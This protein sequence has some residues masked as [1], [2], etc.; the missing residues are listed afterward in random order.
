MT[1]DRY[2]DIRWFLQDMAKKKRKNTLTD[3]EKEEVSS[4]IKDLTPAIRRFFS[5]SPDM[6]KSAPEGT[7]RAKGDYEAQEI[8]PQLP[9]TRRYN[10]ALGSAFHKVL[11]DFYEN[12]GGV[13]EA[14]RQYPPGTLMSPFMGD[15]A[16]VPEAWMQPATESMPSPEEVAEFDRMI[17]MLQAKESLKKQMQKMQE[18]GMFS[19]KEAIEYKEGDI[20]PPWEG[21]RNFKGNLYEDNIEFRVPFPE[22]PQIYSQ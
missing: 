18:L 1:L 22:N 7:T 5:E 8:S 9:L 6:F 19:D 15:Q 14:G 3:T 2:D 13:G 11:P 4:S 16:P 21:K 17:K 12:G 20:L 10:R